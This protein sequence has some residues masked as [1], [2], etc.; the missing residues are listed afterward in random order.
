MYIYCAISRYIDY[1][2]R[3]TRITVVVVVYLAPLEGPTV[4]V[5]KSKKN[6]AEL[7][8]EEIPLDSQRGFITNYTIFY[9]TG[10][11]KQC[12]F[13]TWRMCDVWWFLKLICVDCVWQMWR[14]VLMSIHTCWRI[15]PVKPITWLT[16][17][18]QQKQALSMAWIVLSK[19]WSTVSLLSSF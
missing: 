1:C 19:L 10:N 7:T 13:N 8:W 18:H 11:T 17:W 5:T 3:P 6:S 16:S 15:W 2:D 14:W 12:M 4:T 9:A